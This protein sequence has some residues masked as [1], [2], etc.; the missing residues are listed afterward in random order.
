TIQETPHIMLPN[1]TPAVAHA[2]EAA[3][4]YAH[5][6]G[7][8]EVEPLHLL[9]ALLREEEGR[10][11]VLLKEAGLDVAGFRATAAGGDASPPAAPLPLS[12]ATERLLASARQLA[13]EFATDRTVATEQILLALLRHEAMLRQDLEARGLLTARLEAALTALPGPTLDL[14]EPLDLTG[15]T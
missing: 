10:A 7:A 8:A 3:Q 4:E 2:L 5:R 14:E 9:H 15:P 13:T 12:P 11:S 1:L 6:V